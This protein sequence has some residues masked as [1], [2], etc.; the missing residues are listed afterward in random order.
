MATTAIGERIHFFRAKAGMTQKYL[1][2][3]VGFPER[4][5][6]VRMTQY[7]VGS[8]TSKA[9]LTKSLAGI[10]GVSASSLTVPDIYT[11]IGLMHTLFALEDIRG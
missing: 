5:A 1:G 9:N 10:F 3:T 4:S 11:N 6:D 8:R 2:M 7:E